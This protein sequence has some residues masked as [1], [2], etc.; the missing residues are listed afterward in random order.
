MHLLLHGP[1]SHARP[2]VTIY[3]HM[4]QVIGNSGGICSLVEIHENSVMKY[5]HLFWIEFEHESAPSGGSG[6]SGDIFGTI[7]GITAV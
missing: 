5:L 3:H 7:Y 6:D 1:I 4:Q 2:V